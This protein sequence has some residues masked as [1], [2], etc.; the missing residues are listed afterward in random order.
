MQDSKQAIQ[1]RL[2]AIQAPMEEEADAYGRELAARAKIPAGK[3]ESAFARA[4]DWLWVYKLEMED[5]AHGGSVEQRRKES[6]IWAAAWE[7]TQEKKKTEERRKKC[8]A[9]GQSCE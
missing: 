8:A 6:A 7:K 2:A 4:Q 5:K 9:E 1:D 3:A